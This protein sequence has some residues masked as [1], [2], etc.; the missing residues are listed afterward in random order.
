MLMTNITAL[1]VVAVLA[2]S[3][4][5][6][7][8]CVR[9]CVPGT[10][11]ANATCHDE[12][13]GTFGTARVQHAQ[14]T[15]AQ[16]FGVSPFVIEKTQLTPPATATVSE[17]LASSISASGAAQLTFERDSRRVGTHGATSP[18]VLRL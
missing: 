4:V 5:A 16:L 2:G 1:A 11:H 8:T 9:W 3:P 13:V 10:A 17:P 14:G 15:C 12:Q 6:T 18:V 7:L